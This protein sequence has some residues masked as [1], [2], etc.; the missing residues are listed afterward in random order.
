[1]RTIQRKSSSLH[2][3]NLGHFAAQVNCC[4][5]FRQELGC[6][7]RFGGLPAPMGDVTTK[8]AASTS[9][10]TSATVTTLLALSSNS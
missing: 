7:D 5:S 8:T 2:L 3:P 4:L 1:M 9:I 6:R 10:D